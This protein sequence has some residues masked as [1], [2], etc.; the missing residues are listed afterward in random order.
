MHNGRRIEAAA[1]VRDAAAGNQ[2]PATIVEVCG[3][4]LAL[5]LDPN[6]DITPDRIIEVGVDGHWTPGRVI[7][8]RRGLRDAIVAHVELHSPDAA[9]LGSQRSSTS[10]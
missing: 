2:Q 9:S 3:E 6:V 5:R 10:G 7:W 1:L 4:Q 8:T